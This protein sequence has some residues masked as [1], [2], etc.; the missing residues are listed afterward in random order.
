MN[1]SNIAFILFTLN[2][3]KRIEYPVR[4]FIKYGEVIVLDGGSTDKTGEIAQ[5][6]GATFLQRPKI[7][8]DSTGKD[9]GIAIGET[10]EM[11]DFVLANT[12]KEWIFW[13]YVDDLAP[14]TLL[15][16]LVEISKQDT[17]KQVVIPLHT[18]LWGKTKYPA[19]KSSVG[20]F[21]QRDSVDFS[22]NK[23]HGM[24]TF[25]GK[26][27]EILHLPRHDEYAIRHFSLYNLKKFATNHLAYAEAEAEQKH[28]N[29]QKF[30]TIRMLAA[31]VRYFWLFYKNNWKNG[32]LGFME[33]MA[34]SYFRLQTYFS[35]Y[36]KEHGI[37]LE[38]IEEQYLVQ[39]KRIIDSIENNV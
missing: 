21:F 22:N 34:Y 32:V 28:E 35:L 5:K 8:V 13:Q 20:C 29:R 12:D 30:S 14:R 16:K 18:Y 4:N 10:K 33:A 31:M 37:T 39:K 25:L 27:A 2:E 3:E 1:D 11:L 19:I 23:I 36:E 38:N 24:G 6:Y 15:E 17:Y 7:D 9:V 26:K